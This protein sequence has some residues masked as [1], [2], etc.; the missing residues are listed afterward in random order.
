MV[1]LFH[2]PDHLANY[3]DTVFKQ[4]RKRI[5]KEI[6]Y[7]IS[8]NTPSESTIYNVLQ[9]PMEDCGEVLND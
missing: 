7:L 2:L 3:V 8:D 1:I 5:S 4:V 6:I 9:S